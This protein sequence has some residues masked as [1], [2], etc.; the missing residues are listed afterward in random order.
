LI[1]LLSEWASLIH[2]PEVAARSAALEGATARL[3]PHRAVILRGS[4]RSHLRITV[5]D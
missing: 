1:T 2:H 3:A 5:I 4:L